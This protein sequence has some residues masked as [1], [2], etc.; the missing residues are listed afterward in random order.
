MT[1]TTTLLI[2][3]ALS[4]AATLGF[5][6]GNTAPKQVAAATTAADAAA[7]AKPAV[8]PLH[9]KKKHHKAAV[10]HAAKPA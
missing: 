9:A 6:Q 4:T 5:A 2:A 3:A 8:K 10:K 1:K 7:P